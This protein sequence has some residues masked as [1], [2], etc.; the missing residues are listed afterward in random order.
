MKI[1]EIKA[2]PSSFPLPKEGGVRLGIGRAVKRDC[3]MVMV[4]VMTEDGITG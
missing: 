1:A 4:K 2:Y 3:V